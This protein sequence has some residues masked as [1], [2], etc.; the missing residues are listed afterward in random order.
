[1][2]HQQGFQA[3]LLQDG[4]FLQGWVPIAP[5][6]LVVDRGE[7]WCADVQEALPACGELADTACLDHLLTKGKWTMLTAENPSA[8]PVSEEENES[9][10]EQG[11]GWL[12]ERGYT[13]YLVFGMY[14]GPELSFLIIGGLST[15]HAVEFAQTFDQESV[16]TEQGLVFQNGAMHPRADGGHV[17]IAPVAQAQAQAGGLENYSCIRTAD[18]VLTSFCVEY[19]FTRLIP[20]QH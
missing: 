3:D 11:L 1:M 5:E 19:D 17:Q 9:L 8:A 18:G 12:A 7:Q 16:A 4:D 13:A 14:G 15:A 10:R 6:D 20:V 2:D